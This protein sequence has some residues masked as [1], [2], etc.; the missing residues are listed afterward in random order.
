MALRSTRRAPTTGTTKTHQTGRGEAGEDLEGRAA[1]RTRHAIPGVR[2]RGPTDHPCMR[3]AV[4]FGVHLWR[5]VDFV[6]FPFL[7]E[8][9]VL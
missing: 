7:W 8:W 3:G 5:P 4:G 9:S 1:K 2:V 6:V